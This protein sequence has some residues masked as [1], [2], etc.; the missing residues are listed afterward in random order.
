MDL[1]DPHLLD[2]LRSVR[3][4]LV[5]HAASPAAVGWS[6]ENP[7]GDFRG[8]VGVWAA[9]LEAVRQSEV[10]PRVVFLSS[11]AVYGNPAQLP[12]AESLAPAPISPYGYHKHMCEQLAEY[13][14]R[15]FGLAICS[16]RVFSAYGPGLKRQVLWDICRKLHGSQTIELSGTGEESRDFIHARD[17]ARA[18]A[19]VS[20][21]AAFQAEVYNVA[22]G[23]ATTIAELAAGVAA[24]FGPNHGVRFDGQRREGD[25]LF[26]QADIGRIAALGFRCTV[27]LDEGLREYVAWAKRE[28]ELA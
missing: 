9:L 16:L 5:V 23:R 13:Y 4:D 1:P 17:V 11:A 14:V 27:S 21:R 20:E 8:S 28:P 2:V 3:P 19:C 25:P 12:V 18:V 22:G 7:Y 24:L 26:W 6:L 10:R 15:L